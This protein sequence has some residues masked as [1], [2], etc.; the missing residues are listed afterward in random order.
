MT[1]RR[2]SAIRSRRPDGLH[3]VRAA[4][5]HDVGSPRHETP[6]DALDVR[7]GPRRVLDPAVQ[8][9]HDD[10][11]RRTGLGDDRSGGLGVPRRRR[12]AR[13]S[14]A[15]RVLQRRVEVHERHANTVPHEDRG[16][17]RLRCVETA[18]QRKDADAP[19]RGE[20][21]GDPAGPRVAG[22]VVRDRDGVEPGAGQQSSRG[23][24]RLERVR[25]RS[26]VGTRG[27][28]RLEV[29]DRDVGGTHLSLDVERRRSTDRARR[30]RPRPAPASRRH[31]AGS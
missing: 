19:E 1:L 18:A 8:P 20:G 13:S 27:E 6:R 29:R 22:V 4:R 15:V 11:R 21:V 10:V 26:D 28:R 17:R 14:V 30:R 3:D 25:R 24:V 9:D 23:R 7:I 2:P 31:R 16:R 12:R 5:P